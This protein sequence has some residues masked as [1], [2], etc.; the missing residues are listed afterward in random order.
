MPRSVKAFRA[1]LLVAAGA[2]CTLNILVALGAEFTRNTPTPGFVYWVMVWGSLLGFPLFSLVF[3]SRA[4]LCRALWMLAVTLFLSSY[5][6]LC[7]S[8]AESHCEPAVEQSGSFIVFAV[9][10]AFRSPSVFLTTISALIVSYVLW[11]ERIY[12]SKTTMGINA[13]YTG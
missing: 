2:L 4:W 1:L 12:K 11:I 8:C 10:E 3:F 6:L 7:K 9:R 5:W 13:M